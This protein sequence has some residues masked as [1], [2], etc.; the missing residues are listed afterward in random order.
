MISASLF[1]FY[2]KRKQ[3]AS[4]ETPLMGESLI[5]RSSSEMGEYGIYLLTSIFLCSNAIFQKD[6]M[7]LVISGVNLYA[8][9]G[10]GRWA[11]YPG[12][13]AFVILPG[14]LRLFNFWTQIEGVALAVVSG[15]LFSCLAVYSL[16]MYDKAHE[17]SIGFTLSCVS[18]LT[19]FL[20]LSSLELIRS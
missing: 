15:V 1:H 5:E 12:I 9:A 16:P 7:S 19:L 10:E 4:L 17:T 13:V 3:L 8:V 6:L 11:N 14:L 2:P 18:V 20:G